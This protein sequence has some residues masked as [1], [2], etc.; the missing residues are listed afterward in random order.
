M[1]PSVIDAEQAVH[2]TGS[3]DT[4][5]PEHA[6]SAEERHGTVDSTPSA[7]IQADARPDHRTGPSDESSPSSGTDE[8]G[9]AERH[10]ASMA[11]AAF[12]GMA[13]GHHW[14]TSATSHE[15]SRARMHAEFAPAGIEV[16]TVVS[17]HATCDSQSCLGPWEGPKAGIGRRRP[18]ADG[19]A[20]AESTV[21]G[22]AALPQCG[23]SGWA[24]RRACTDGDDDTAICPVCSRR[25]GTRPGPNPRLPMRIVADHAR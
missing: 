14:C 10:W 18:V 23:A 1:T 5:T 6:G 2:S 24:L 11:A 13:M 15:R 9:S 25:V 21:G 3:M 12:A 20:F 22:D 17:V 4:S 7:R 8:T 16:P 19:S